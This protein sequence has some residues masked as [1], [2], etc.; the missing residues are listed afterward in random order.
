MCIYVKRAVHDDTEIVRGWDGVH[1]QESHPQTADL[2]TAALPGRTQGQELRP[3]FVE[4]E[5][6]GCHPYSELGDA[7]L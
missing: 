2:H 5:L 6:V 1:L 3:N 7:G 4:V